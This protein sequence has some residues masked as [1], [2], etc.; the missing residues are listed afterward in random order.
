MAMARLIIGVAGEI[1]AGK[2]TVT[3]YITEKHGAKYYRYSIILKDILRRLHLPYDRVSLANL[4][5]ALRAYFGENI[6]SR[7]LIA[8]AEA[9]LDAEIVVFDGIRKIGELEFLKTLPNF[10]FLFVHADMPVRYQRLRKRG[11]KTDDLSKT[12]EQFMKDHE[13][14]A[15]NV[16]PRLREHAHRIIDNNGTLEDMYRQIDTAI[17]VFRSGET[18]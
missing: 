10:R 18:V 7:T 15:D 4:A 1:G 14:A 12:M 16:I 9:D 2:D 11:E 13:H 3:A 8:D 5:E 6:L 17:K